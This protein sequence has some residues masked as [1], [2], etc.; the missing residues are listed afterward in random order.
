MLRKSISIKGKNVYPYRRKI[1]LTDIDIMAG[2]YVAYM[3]SASENLDTKVSVQNT[4]NGVVT[5][6]E[7]ERGLTDYYHKTMGIGKQVKITSKDSL[8]IPVSP[9]I[10]PYLPDRAGI[11]T[12]LNKFDVGVTASIGMS[13]ELSPDVKLNIGGNYSMGLLTIDKEYYSNLEYI[14]VPD[15]SGSPD[16]NLA[17]ITKE[18]TK[19]DLKNTGFG[20]Y[21]GVVKYMK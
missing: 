6:T 21:I 2:P 14:I 1:S 10:Y 20:F 16:I 15:I 8:A 19:V 12:G 11:S 5:A 7:A 3:I 17:K 13:F 4:D 18:V 9:A